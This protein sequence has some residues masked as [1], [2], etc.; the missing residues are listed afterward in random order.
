MKRK[1]QEVESI[2]SLRDLESIASRQNGHKAKDACWDS[3]RDPAAVQI[4]SRGGK[5]LPASA[6]RQAPL[7][8]FTTA[9][10]PL[11]DHELPRRVNPH[12]IPADEGIRLHVSH[13]QCPPRRQVPMYAGLLENPP[14]N[15]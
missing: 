5:G 12:G 14:R 9:N 11:F 7:C 15:G 13:R 2:D 3:P 4:R 1:G 8:D 10:S 6:A